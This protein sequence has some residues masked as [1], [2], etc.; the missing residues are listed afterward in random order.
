MKRFKGLTLLISMCFFQSS[1]A[2]LQKAGYYRVWQGFKKNDLSQTQFLN[3][4]PRFM[5]D[6]QNIYEGRALN[7]YLSE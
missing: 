7:Q 1:Y 4:L 3:A 5:Q 2:Q 6:T